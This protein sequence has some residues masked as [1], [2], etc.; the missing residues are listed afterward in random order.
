MEW[1]DTHLGLSNAASG[2]GASPAAS[3][4][5]FRPIKHRKFVEK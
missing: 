3:A 5:G 4:A 2:E 1:F